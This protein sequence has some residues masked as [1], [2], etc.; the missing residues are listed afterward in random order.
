MSASRV[1]CVSMS[2]LPPACLPPPGLWLPF[3]DSTPTSRIPSPPRA[4]PPAPP[5]F[6]FF[7]PSPLLEYFFSCVCRLLLIELE[8]LQKTAFL[9]LSAS[10]GS[11]LRSRRN[12][13]DRIDARCV[14]YLSVCGWDEENKAL[15][16]L[17]LPPLLRSRSNPTPCEFECRTG[18]IG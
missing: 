4:P 17:L 13:H 1:T 14:T 10:D 18:N 3:F 12:F 5:S 6:F 7:L 8:W 11:F 2:F 15:L 9:F 16:L